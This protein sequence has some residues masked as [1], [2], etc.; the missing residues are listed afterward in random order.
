MSFD[1]NLYALYP[2]Q[3]K[4]WLVAL[5]TFLKSIETKLSIRIAA[6]FSNLTYHYVAQATSA[7]GEILI[8]KCGIPHKEM[9]TEIAA[10]QHYDG[11]GCVKLITSDAEQGWLL[12]EACQP[13]VVLATLEDDAVATHHAVEVMQKLWKPIAKEEPFPTIQ[14]WLEGLSRMQHDPRA[15]DLISKR[16]MDYSIGLSK[17]LSASMGELILLHGDLHH[18]NILSSSRAPYLAIDPKGLIGERE[19]ECGALIR[20]PIA[21]IRGMSGLSRFLKRRLDQMAAETGFDRKRIQ[22]WSMVQA[23]LAV[24]WQI[25]DGGI[26]EQVWIQCAEALV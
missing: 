13:G 3:A 8:F 22:Q 20:N 23:V 10:L 11:Q 15:K 12:I 2:N 4:D 18:D 25:E 1:E 5:P 14:N 16:L 17:D 6:P 19:Y 7:D 9:R 26:N 24:Y 21:K